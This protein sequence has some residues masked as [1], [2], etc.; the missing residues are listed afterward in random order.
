LFATAKDVSIGPVAVM[1]LTVSQIITY[2][3]HKHPHEWSNPEIAINLAF[4]CGFI[5]LGI[6]LLRLGW[7]VELIPIPAVAGFITGSALNIAVGQLPGLLGITGFEFVLPSLVLKCI[8]DVLRNSTRAATYHVFINTLK[9][10]GR[11]KKDAAF[12]IVGLFALYAIRMSCN[13]LSRRYPRR[14]LFSHP[15]LSYRISLSPHRATLFLH[16]GFPQC[17]RDYR[18][19][20]GFVAVYPSS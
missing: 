4:I 15:S 2:V 19:D 17:L 11:T 16:L 8:S 18:P 10:L 20:L 14:G 13:Y 3:D 6:G 12:G 9:G 5:V 1:S 7:L